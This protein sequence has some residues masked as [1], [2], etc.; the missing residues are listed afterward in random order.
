MKVKKLLKKLKKAGLCDRLEKA[1]VIYEGLRWSGLVLPRDVLNSKA[2]WF[3]M[4]RKGN[5][6][7]Y[8]EGKKGE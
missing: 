1:T 8:T 7:I 5:T 2:S 6:E 3:Q 4:D